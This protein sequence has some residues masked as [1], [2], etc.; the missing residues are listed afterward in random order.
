MIYIIWKSEEQWNE[1]FG[2]EGNE[3]EGEE[4]VSRS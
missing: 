4:K 2:G 3:S 1:M